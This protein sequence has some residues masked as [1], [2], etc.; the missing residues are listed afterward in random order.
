[1]AMQNFRDAASVAWTLPLSQH[2]HG[3]A[4]RVAAFGGEVVA[5][6]VDGVTDEDHC[7]W[8][9]LVDP[10]DGL[11]MLASR[12]R[13]FDDDE[14]IYL[15]VVWPAPGDYRDDSTLV[16]LGVAHLTRAEADALA[17]ELERLDAQ[18]ARRRRHR[19]AEEGA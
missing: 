3:A 14:E 13:D 5:T 16:G 15:R 19:T 8:D 17:S 9:P 18:P 4:L 1:M 2:P 12:L 10:G 11:A 7:R 6:L